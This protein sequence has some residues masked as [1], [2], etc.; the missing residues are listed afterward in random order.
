VDV[1]ILKHWI[2]EGPVVADLF[3][4][5]RPDALV[6]ESG[7]PG[8]SC[9]PVEGRRLTRPDAA[10]SLGQFLTHCGRSGA[11]FGLKRL[12]ASGAAGGARIGRRPAR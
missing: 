3:L 12:A 6:H 11:Y 1:N 8:E 5:W 2:D 9:G 7:R 10:A 4:S